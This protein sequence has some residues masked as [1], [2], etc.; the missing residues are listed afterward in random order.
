[1]ILPI[2]HAPNCAIIA[3]VQPEC[4]ENLCVSRE[5]AKEQTF[6]PA[7]SLD[8]GCERE[9]YGWM[10]SVKSGAGSTVLNRLRGGFRNTDAVFNIVVRFLLCGVGRDPR[11]AHGLDRVVDRIDKDPHVFE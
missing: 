3:Y 10:G 8:V 2:L 11:V 1:M 6:R 5:T 4:N 9:R 7:L